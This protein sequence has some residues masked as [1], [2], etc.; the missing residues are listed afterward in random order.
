MRTT[1]KRHNKCS[2]IVIQNLKNTKFEVFERV[3]N[4]QHQNGRKPQQFDQLTHFDYS[5]IEFWFLPQISQ[6]D[7]PNL[8]Y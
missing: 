5:K 2:D 3:P 6:H 7:N 1:I 4:N 8:F